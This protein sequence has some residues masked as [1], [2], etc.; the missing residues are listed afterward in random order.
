ML[1]ALGRRKSQS[2]VLPE[3]GFNLNMWTA[4]NTEATI[5][6]SE[7]Q[8]WAKSAQGHLWRAQCAAVLLP[9]FLFV[10]RG[11]KDFTPEQGS[12]LG[13][14]Q[15]HTQSLSEWHLASKKDLDAILPSDPPSQSL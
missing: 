5:T 3:E 2:H 7:A 15:S 6:G 1:S 10:W 4:Q 9:F 8:F 14:R 13:G 12:P 11:P